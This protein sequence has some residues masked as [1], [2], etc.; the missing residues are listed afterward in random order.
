ME[1]NEK[2]T[3]AIV[4]I[5]VNHKIISSAEGK[6][7][8]KGFRDSAKP[9][10]TEFI[11]D[12]RLVDDVNLLKAYS[13]HYKVPAFDVVS[14]FFDYH[15]LHMFPKGF[16]LRNAIIP[17]QR[18]ENILVM[19]ASKPDDSE[20]LIKIGEHVSYG[21][22]FRVGLHHD[23][24]DA[25]KEFYDKAPTQV[26]HDLDLRKK[27]LELKETLTQEQGETIPYEEEDEALVE[28]ED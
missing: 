19:I 10:F 23:I 16:L 25:I 22:R 11:R 21:I 3:Q 26:Q 12:Q 20:L 6:A 1:N 2:F 15:L 28:E 13:I 18:D 4:N 14:H 7:L 9:S 24:S 27:R 5:L 17:L 8:V